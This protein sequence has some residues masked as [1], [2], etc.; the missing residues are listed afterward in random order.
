MKFFGLSRRVDWLVERTFRRGELS[1]SSGLK[2]E[3][4]RFSETFAS[5]NQTNL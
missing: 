1:A 5:A 2:K 4:A 3:T